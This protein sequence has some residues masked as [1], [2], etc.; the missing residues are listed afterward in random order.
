M[1]AKPGVTPPSEA[2]R[3]FVGVDVVDLTDPRAR[4]R[5]RD[6]RFLDRVFS[7][8]ERERIRSADDP[9]LEVWILWAAKEA[10][11]KVFSK[12]HGELPVFRH[13][14]Y[15]VTDEPGLPV[16]ALRYGDSRLALGVETHPER[17]LAWAWNGGA[18]EILVA[19]ST[20]PGALAT[21]GLDPD[22]ER[23]EAARFRPRERD[24]IHGL[25]SALVRLLA[26]RDAAHMLGIQEDVL[27]IE[28]PPGH[29][30]L[31]PPYLHRTGTILRNAD[32]SLS[33]DGRQL[34]WAVR[35]AR[36]VGG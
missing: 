20:V 18:P 15:E 4:D 36:S 26:R 35:V 5:S 6:T 11:F 14:A 30:G 28:C 17:V 1:K 32:V 29:T 3:P 21:L 27:S 13:A 31:R 10:A 9:A 23:W 2:G 25:P 8:L 16:T 34:A 19:R 22:R 24:S 33:H 7:P 12:L